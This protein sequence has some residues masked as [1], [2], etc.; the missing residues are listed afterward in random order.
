LGRIAKHPDFVTGGI[1]TGFIARQAE[2]LLA[3][4]GTP[5]SDVLA[6]VAL[7]VLAGEAVAGDDPW[8]SRDQWWLNI[9][10][11]RTMMFTDGTA[12]YP[13][14]VRR[15]GANWLIGETTGVAEP[16]A[17]DGLRVALDGTWRTV[18]MAEDHHVITLRD[19]GQTWRLTLPDPLSAD[20]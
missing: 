2:T 13:V 12:Q 10:R 18:L 15:D 4:Q 20:D 5:P 19:A 6:I 11:V 8:D 16:Q 9:A 7:A 1:D 3:P 17:G 14:E